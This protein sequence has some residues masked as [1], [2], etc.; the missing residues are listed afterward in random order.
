M[1]ACIKLIN[2]KGGVLYT[3]IDL[4]KTLKPFKSLYFNSVGNFGR[5]TFGGILY[6]LSRSF[7]PMF[8]LA[9][10]VYFIFQNKFLGIFSIFIYQ[11]PVFC[12]VVF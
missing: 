2:V 4:A 12:V 6:F 8:S 5:I 9:H 1:E 11:A 10:Q 3:E 7:L